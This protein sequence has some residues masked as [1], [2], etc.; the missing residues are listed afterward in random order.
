MTSIVDSEAHFLKRA[1]EVH[2][3][4]D[5]VDALQR[6]GFRSV[7]QLAFAVGQPGQVIPEQDFQQFCKTVAPSASQASI[8]SIRRLLFEA[9]TLSVQQLRLQLTSPDSAAKHVSEAERDRRLSALRSSLTGL[10][11]EGPLEPGRR[12]LDECAHQEALGQLKYLAPERCISRLHEV[13]HAKQPTKQ[14]SL[15]QNRLVI[16]EESADLSM[17][18][19]SALQALEALRRR[20]LAYVFSQSVSWGPYDK[21]LTKLFGRM[22]RGP[23]PGFNRISVSQL[24]EADRKVFSR[25]IEL[26]VKP[27]KASD[28]TFPMDDALMQALE[29][30]EVSFSLMRLQSR[31]A[32]PPNRPNKRQREEDT[33]KGKGKS[34]WS[35]PKGKGKNKSS[36]PWM[37]IPKVIRDKGGVAQLPSGE[38]LCFDFNI[39][40]DGAKCK[41]ETCPRKHLCAKCFGQHPLKDHKE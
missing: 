40:G 36:P 38:A 10:C 30:Y 29:S 26:D 24:I 27:R 18:A 21:Y 17:P 3:E 9:Q 12:L 5:A 16:Q 28:G 41:A 34:K 33:R 14:V 22:H 31:A 11:I 35:Q 4:Q 6:H 20:G 23:P 15:E 8:A 7:G 1:A 39:H 13:T 25:L 2:L 19:A 37:A 32:P